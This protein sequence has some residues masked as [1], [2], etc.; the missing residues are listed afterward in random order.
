[1]ICAPSLPNIIRVMKKKNYKVFNDKRGYDLN[2][3]GIRTNNNKSNTFNDWLV[4]FYT[5][6]NQW[7]YFTFP[8]TTDPGLYYRENPL[9]VDGTAIVVPNQYRNLWYIG[10]HNDYD[11]LIQK[12]P[13]VVYRD[14]NLDDILN[15]VVKTEQGMFGINCHRASKDYKSKTVDKWSAGCQVFQNPLHFKFFL[16]LCQFSKSIYGN[17]FSYTLLNEKDF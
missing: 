11:A 10:K 5:Y 12:S 6:Q 14:N 3:V 13:I 17:S 1:M 15:D 9:N 2:I 7:S 16:T 8:I 4:T